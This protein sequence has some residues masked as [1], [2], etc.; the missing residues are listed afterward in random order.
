MKSW[1]SREARQKPRQK[2]SHHSLR[3]SPA[4]Q[5]ESLFVEKF[6]EILQFCGFWGLKLDLACGKME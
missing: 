5:G 3:D 6:V 2:F 4:Y 1:Y